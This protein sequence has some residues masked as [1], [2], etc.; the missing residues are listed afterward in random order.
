[1]EHK[2]GS[3]LCKSKICAVFAQMRNSW[4]NLKFSINHLIKKAWNYSAVLSN[5]FLVATAQL[6]RPCGTAKN[7]MIKTFSAIRKRIISTF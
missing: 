1:M 2:L 5:V 7:E 4:W 6:R 3:L